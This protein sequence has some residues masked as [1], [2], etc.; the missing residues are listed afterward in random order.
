MGI[1][2]LKRVFCPRGKKTD[3]KLEGGSKEEKKRGKQGYKKGWR[4]DGKG[5]EEG[6]RGKLI[7]FASNNRTSF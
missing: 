5:K 6:K 7:I 1:Q 2:R 3:R 4:E